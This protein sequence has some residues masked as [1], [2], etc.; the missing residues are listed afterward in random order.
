MPDFEEWFKQNRSYYE[1]KHDGDSAEMRK[2]AMSSYRA[3]KLFMSSP[4][5]D[6]KAGIKKK[7]N[8]YGFD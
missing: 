2:D 8:P 6:Q 3:I 5:K 7:P 4:V 1:V